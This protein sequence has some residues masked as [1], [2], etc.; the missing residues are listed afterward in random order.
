MKTRQKLRHLRIRDANGVVSNRGGA[1]VAGI[2]DE[3][4]KLLR[5]AVAYCHNKDNFNR[6]VGKV[7]A[8]N[9]LSGNG[10]FTDN[11]E[12][13][14]VLSRVQEDLNEVHAQHLEDQREKIQRK[15]AVLERK[16]KK[17]G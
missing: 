2:V 3:N 14:E 8:T 17:L 10:A 9:R 13:D 7:K 5:F 15:I 4:G 12:W 11:L 1:T 16:L 6:L